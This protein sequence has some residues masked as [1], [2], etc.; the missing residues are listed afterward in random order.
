VTWQAWLTFG[1][2]VLICCLGP[3]RRVFW[4]SWRF[5]LP[6]SAAG[7]S[8]VWLTPHLFPGDPWWVGLA[9]GGFVGL[10]VGAACKEWLDQA[11]GERV[12]D[13]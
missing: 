6:A 1:V 13:R 11:L 8:T 5:C 9:V 4:R 3:L 12:A 10:G 2:F 7:W